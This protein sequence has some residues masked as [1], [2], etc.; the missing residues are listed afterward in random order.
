VQPPEKLE[1]GKLEAIV[2]RLYIQNQL[3]IEQINNMNEFIKEKQWH[4]ENG[5]ESKGG[6]V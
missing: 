1:I 3:L 2:G 5:D 6:N 4:E